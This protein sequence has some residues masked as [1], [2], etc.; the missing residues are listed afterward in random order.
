[1]GSLSMQ[2][3]ALPGHNASTVGEMLGSCDGSPNDLLGFFF[4]SVQSFE[5]LP[6]FFN[7]QI[8]V[9]PFGGITPS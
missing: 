4:A 8:I 2:P 1:M 3:T 5:D 9:G 7:V 6:A